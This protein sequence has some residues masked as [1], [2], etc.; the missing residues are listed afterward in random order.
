L[1]HGEEVLKAAAREAKLLE[2]GQKLADNMDSVIKLLGLSG[3][4][5]KLREDLAA[6]NAA[7]KSRC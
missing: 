7:V 6:W 4:Y 3:R 5:P 2:A 1:T